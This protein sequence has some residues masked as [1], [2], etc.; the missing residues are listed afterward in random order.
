MLFVDKSRSP[1]S[2]AMAKVRLALSAFT[3]VFAF[4]ASAVP[5]LKTQAE[6]VQS[7][8]VKIKPLAN[9]EGIPAPTPESH[10]YRITRG[11]ESKD[12][13]FYV[14]ADIWRVRAYA[15]AWKDKKGNV[16]RLSSV[17]SLIPEF[18]REDW[19]REEIDSKLDKMEESFEGTDEELAAWEKAWGGS[20]VG[21]FVTV[22]GGKRFY[23]DFTF[24]EPVSDAVAQKLLKAAAASVSAA[25]GGMSANNSSMKWWSTEN[26]QYKFMT[27]LDKAKGGKFVGDA[28]KLMS[29]MRRSYEFYVPPSGS[30]GLCTVRVFRTLEGYRGYLQS[31][32]SEMEWSCGL[33]DPSREELL[34]SAED[35]EQ[36]QR[37][38]RHEAFHQY[39][40]YA[41]K[42]GNHALWFNEGHACFFEN[43]QY[44][45]AKNTV[46]VIDKGNRATWVDKNPAAVANMIPKVVAMSREEF[47]SGD[48]NMH[49]VASWAVV[50]FLEKGAYVSEEFAPYR[51]VVSEYLK[52][53]A[54]GADAQT[55]T[56]L[57]W[58]GIYDLNRNI[59][60]DFL[61]FWTKHRKQS[62]NAR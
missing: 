59:P 43:V 13:K 55:A 31:T 19:Y 20:G 4:C 28:M 40:H 56:A 61:K 34:V 15:G 5:Q 21:K 8:G 62:I 33:W 45:P 44:N 53:A 37:T 6:L 1:S 9:A 35:R 3:A 49:Y 7:A 41:T 12:V 54:S 42:R 38:M 30:V 36:A 46:K 32:N 24:A 57:A 22:R 39:L 51:K 50:Y 48:V 29:A 18:E 23:I 52:A 47:Y 27:D 10:S 11:G 2:P 26:S 58:K 16:M 14:P 17:R 60:D 25:T